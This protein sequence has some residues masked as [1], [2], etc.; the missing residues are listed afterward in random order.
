[1]SL[2]SFYLAHSPPY[3]AAG[4]TPVHQWKRDASDR[5][6]CN[7]P[8][9]QR[10]LEGDWTPDSLF[11]HASHRPRQIRQ[12]PATPRNR[13]RRVPLRSSRQT[14]QQAPPTW[15]PAWAT[16]PIK[17]RLGELTGEAHTHTV[18]TNRYTAQP[19][20]D[21]HAVTKVNDSYRSSVRLS[22]APALLSLLYFTCFSSQIHKWNYIIFPI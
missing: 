8:P 4:L 7:Y 14:L 1:M 16:S 6:T 22:H 21:A 15:D 12:S 17:C 9:T 3:I 20:S 11:R 2:L 10:S 5:N 13:R 19:G 18:G